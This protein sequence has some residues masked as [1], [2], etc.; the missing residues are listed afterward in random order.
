MN[1]KKM[2]IISMKCVC[3]CVCVNDMIVVDLLMLGFV[4][5]L[6]RVKLVLS[7]VRVTEA[8]S[9]DS[10]YPFEILVILYIIKMLL[11]YI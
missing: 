5:G 8:P 4:R 11:F 7:R 6:S 2:L 1:I 9:K 3:V 10:T